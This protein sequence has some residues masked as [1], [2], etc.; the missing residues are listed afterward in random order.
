MRGEGSGHGLT[1]GSRLFQPLWPATHRVTNPPGGHYRLARSKSIFSRANCDMS[2]TPTRKPDWA[3]LG[4]LL[5]PSGSSG[6]PFLD[7]PSYS[8][9][10]VYSDFSDLMDV[11]QLQAIVSALQQSCEVLLTSKRRTTEH[12]SKVLRANEELVADNERLRTQSSVLD[13]PYYRCEV[14]SK[15]FKTQATLLKHLG[16]KHGEVS[17]PRPSPPFTA[18]H[19]AP[20]LAYQQLNNFS[21]SELSEACAAKVVEAM[22]AHQQEGREWIAAEF[23]VAVRRAL[24]LQALVPPGQSWSGDLDL[25]AGSFLTPSP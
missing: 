6:T 2:R 22:T 3:R 12:L 1:C 23:Q 9:D 13:I 14:C 18:S 10:L 15:K 24:E 7:L 21:V 8:D 4:S 19:P 25:S 20:M 17:S 11:P 5:G 16:R